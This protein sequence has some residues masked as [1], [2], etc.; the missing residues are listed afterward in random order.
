MYKRFGHSIINGFPGDLKITVNIIN[1]TGIV[2]EG[3][4]LIK[5]IQIPYWKGILGG[6]V[7]YDYFGKKWKI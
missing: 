3:L 6:F 7:K 4:N 5:I 1:N 2:R